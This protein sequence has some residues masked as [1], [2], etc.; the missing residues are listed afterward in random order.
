MDTLIDGLDSPALRIRERIGE[1]HLNDLYASAPELRKEAVIAFLGKQPA[2]KGERSVTFSRCEHVDW[3]QFQSPELSRR[4]GNLSV[5]GQRHLLDQIRK[6]LKGHKLTVLD[7]KV[8]WS[9]QNERTI[10]IEEENPPYVEDMAIS[11]SLL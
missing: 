4:Y 8:Q 1:C 9:E 2:K 6:V 11:F 5:E 10:R 3:L 7:I